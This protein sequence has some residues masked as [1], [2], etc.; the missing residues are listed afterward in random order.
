[1]NYKSFLL[2]GRMKNI[3]YFSLQGIPE[4]PSGITEKYIKGNITKFNF[5]KTVSIVDINDFVLLFPKFKL[6]V[7]C[8][9]FD[10]NSDKLQL[11]L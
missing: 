1:M 8:F 5:L 9:P 11:L 3:P 4:I 6:L 10:Q 7:L 2:I